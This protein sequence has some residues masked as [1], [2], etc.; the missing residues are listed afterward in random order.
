[1]HLSKILQIITAHSGIQMLR[2]S[3]YIEIVN[4]TRDETALDINRSEKLM[5]VNL[6]RRPTIG[7]SQSKIASNYGG[8]EKKIQPQ[9]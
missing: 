6:F 4:N 3:T 9:F 5:A 2:K 7:T 8:S 1:M